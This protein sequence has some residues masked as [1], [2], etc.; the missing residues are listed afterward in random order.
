MPIG[1][2]GTNGLQWVVVSEQAWTHKTLGTAHAFKFWSPMMK[3]TVYHQSQTSCWSPMINKLLWATHWSLAWRHRIK[4]L[5]SCLPLEIIGTLH[6]GEFVKTLWIKRVSK[7]VG[8]SWHWSHKNWS[9]F[10][11]WKQKEQDTFH[12]NH[13][14]GGPTTVQLQAISSQ[15]WGALDSPLDHDC[16][17]APARKHKTTSASVLS[18]WPASLEP[19]WWVDDGHTPATH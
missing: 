6:G 4:H 15:S 5:F 8:L 3:Q 16:C 10:P 9:Y 18:C 12:P 13:L 14:H 1:C 2:M 7:H 17:Q 11:S 19:D